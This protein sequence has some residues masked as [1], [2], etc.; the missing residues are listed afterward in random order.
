MYEVHEPEKNEE[1]MRFLQKIHPN[2][3]Y[4]SAHNYNAGFIN[5]WIACFNGYKEESDYFYGMKC[6][7]I[8][9]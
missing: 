4:Q 3:E 5:N 8:K 9:V 1:L 6:V 2:E 7:G